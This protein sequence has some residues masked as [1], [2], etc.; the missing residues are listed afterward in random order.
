MT[1]TLLTLSPDNTLTLPEEL[2]ELLGIRP[3]DELTLEPGEG[4][5]TLR[6]HLPTH[7]ASPITP[8]RQ[9]VKRKNLESPIQFI[10]GVGPKLAENLGRLNIA[11]VEDA[12]YLV[13]NRYEDRRELHT[14][15]ELRPGTV[16]SFAGTILAAGSQLSKGGKSYFEAVI[17]DGS[18]SIT[19]K[20]FRFNARDM[21]NSWNVGRRG[22]FTGMEIFRPFPKPLDESKWSSMVPL[23]APMEPLGSHSRQTEDLPCPLR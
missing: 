9:A 15:V 2:R 22:L 6:R 4:S 16:E 12:L 10:K 7:V 1:V 13:P 20:W 3:G 11:T 18:G 23:S 5:V 21:T 19:C 17:G 8:F 14:I